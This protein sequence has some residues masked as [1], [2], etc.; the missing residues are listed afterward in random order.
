MQPV[1]RKTGMADIKLSYFDFHGGRG[2]PARL[3][4]FIG[5]ID[6]EDDRLSFADFFK[7]KSAFPYGALPVLWVDGKV[8][9][10]SSGI[11]RYV[12]KL[13]GLYP[14]DPWQ[15][16]LCDEVMDAVEDVA[17]RVGPTLSIKD[18]EEKKSARKALVDGP[19][20]YFLDRIENRLKQ[21]GGTYFADDRLTVADLRVFVWVRH[22][23]SGKLDHVP[24]D[25]PEKVAPLLAEHADRIAALPKVIA[26]YERFKD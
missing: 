21:A 3:A 9:A 13:A 25:L 16:A 22:I 6:F 17:H 10:Q 26:Y 11:N 18:P 24:T 14:S 19:I 8:L 20:T 12:G 2:E 1:V 5:D 4:L 23:R 15:Q 7:A